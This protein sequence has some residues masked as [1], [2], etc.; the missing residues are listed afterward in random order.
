MTSP[1]DRTIPEAPSERELDVLRLIADGDMNS[2]IAAD[3]CLSERTVKYHVTNLLRKFQARDRAHLVA[4]AF[5]GGLLS[6]DCTQ[7]RGGE[8]RHPIACSSRS[9]R[10]RP[11]HY[12]RHE[13]TL[14]FEE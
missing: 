8:S 5:R 11:H 13:E 14:S 2:V 6:V 7:V 12:T 4:K 9:E 3:L 1:L 10:D